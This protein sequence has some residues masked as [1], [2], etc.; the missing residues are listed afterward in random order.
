MPSCFTLTEIGK[1]EPSVINDIDKDL[2]DHFNGGEP[3]GNEKYY[4]NWYNTIGIRLA[5]GKTFAEIK[6]VYKDN[7]ISVIEYLESKYVPNAWREYR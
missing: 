7:D 3:K 1:S 6:E 5:M 2:W 4:R